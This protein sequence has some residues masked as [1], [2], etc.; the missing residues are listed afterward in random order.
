[1]ADPRIGHDWPVESVDQQPENGSEAVWCFQCGLEY[2]PDVVECV[3]CGVPTTDRPPVT[4]ESVGDEDD[5]QM[6]YELHE[7]TGQGRSILDGMLTRSG[8][9]HAWQGATLIVL[10]AD[11][12]VVDDAI[13]QTEIVAMPTLDLNEP[14]VVYELGELERDQHARL[15]RRLGD[16]GI[17]HAFDKNGDLFAYERDEAAVDEIFEGLDEADASEREFGPG[18]AGIE[19]VAVITDLFVAAGRLRKRPGDPKGVVPFVDTA[20]TVNQMRLP[21]GMSADQWGSIVDQTNELTDMLVGDGDGIVDT[22]D[23][24]VKERA[25][26]LHTVLRSIV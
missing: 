24:I 11:E 9:P 20:A 19:P 1:M 10:E 18:V 7:W 17:S 3:E 13:A 14:T 8:V 23:A 15:L 26:E 5:D 2:G 6:A 4:A 25:T 16:N 21:Y 22:D 12:E